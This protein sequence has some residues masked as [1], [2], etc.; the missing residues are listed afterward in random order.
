MR[1]VFMAAALFVLLMRT[2]VPAG[3]MPTL[4][5]GRMVV[6]LCTGTGPATMVL[7]LGKTTPAPGDKHDGDHGPCAFSGGFTGGLIQAAP[8]SILLPALALMRLPQG[9]RIADLTVHRLAA[10]PP[11]AIGPPSPL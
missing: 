1:G 10:P 5:D 7:D 6:Q 3:F 9:G 4:Q 8:P 11:P 2:L